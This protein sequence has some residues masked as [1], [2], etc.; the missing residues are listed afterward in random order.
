MAFDLEF[1]VRMARRLAPYQLRWIEDCLAPDDMD[2]QTALRA[3]LPGPRRG[4]AG[5]ARQRR[6]ASAG[7]PGARP[8]A[9]GD[10]SLAERIP[11]SMKRP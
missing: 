11:W 1:A 3:R 5:L 4:A 7:A 8:L 6:C 10:A 9:R 2:G